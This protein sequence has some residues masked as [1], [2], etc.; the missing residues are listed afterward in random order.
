MQKFTFNHDGHYGSSDDSDTDV[1]GRLIDV[2]NGAAL[3]GRWGLVQALVGI[4]AQ[5]QTSN[6][7]IHLAKLSLATIGT[8][9]AYRKSKDP[10]ALDDRANPIDEFIK[11]KGISIPVEM[12]NLEHFIYVYSVKLGYTDR[13]IPNTKFVIRQFRSKS[14]I[15]Y[16]YTFY[17]PD[18]SKGFWGQGPLVHPDHVEQF[19]KDLAELIWSAEGNADLQLTHSDDNYRGFFTLSNIG[20]ANDFVSADQTWSNV[21]KLAER[22]NAFKRKGL[23]R[24]ILFYG[25]P[26]TG[27]TTLARSLA[28]GVG[29]TLRIESKAL[30][31]AGG[32]AVMKFVKLLQP[33]VILFDDMDRNRSSSEEFLHYMEQV[34]NG[35]KWARCLVIIGTVNAIDHIDPALLR[36]GRFDEVIEIKEPDETH[37]KAIIQHYAQKFG[38]LEDTD[39]NLV[40]KRTD[41]FAPADI[42]NIL[43]TCASVGIQHLEA[44][45]ERV[46]LQRAL[47][48]GESVSEYLSRKTDSSRR[49]V[50]SHR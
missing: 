19:S 7:Y 22:C 18:N 11:S 34:G 24:R 33:Q 26:G 45:I 43:I 39:V 9:R 48:S 1:I 44:E 31:S 20:E 17:D 41:G 12:E 3:P 35:E 38:I 8:L 32:A 42:E 2:S 23:S 49:L 36:P 5:E 10:E 21:A 50:P 30:E 14:G 37:R 27:K 16:Y 6:K 40:L 47:F 25:P 13:L 4:W 46:A 28:K 15:E 29:H